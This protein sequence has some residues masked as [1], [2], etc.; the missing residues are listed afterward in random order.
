MVERARLVE[1]EGY[2]TRERKVPDGK[3]VKVQ[4]NPESL[5]LSFANEHKGG[6][7]PG[8]SSRQFVG[9]A[10]S[11]MSVELLFDTTAD[12]SDV[13]KETEE[14]A[15][16]IMAKPGKKKGS[17]RVPP[18]VRFEW[19]SFIFEGV[20]DS[21]SETLEYFSEQGVPL[22]A[23]VGLNLSRDDL[24]FLFG[25][26][27]QVGAGTLS[28]VPG[29]PGTTSLERPRPGDSVQSMAGRGGRSR[30]WRAIAEANDIDDP[31]RLP[32]ET[33][34]D[35]NVGAGGAAGF[36]AGLGGGASIGGSLG[37]DTSE[38]PIAG[39]GFGLGVDI[40]EG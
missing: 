10:S 7:Q 11:K 15:Y 34:L 4:F 30:D 5:K 13:R 19:G 28:N 2:S 25:K 22:R 3:E 20:V 16:F 27:G 21:M 12:G 23:T 6:D 38:G 40:V 9:S 17:K 32:P 31:L 8:G 39:G 24:V 14:V 33:L 1:I 35:M 29:A 26:P 36:G 37:T 18:K